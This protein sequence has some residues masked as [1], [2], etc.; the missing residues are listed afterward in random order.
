MASQSSIEWTDATWNP[1][2]GCS[3]ISAGCKFCYAERLAL[4]LQAMGQARY[5]GGFSI[6]LQD[7]LLDLPR[8]WRSPRLVF[9]NSMSD[10]FHEN[11]PLPFIRRVFETWRSVF[12]QAAGRRPEEGDRPGVGWQ[13]LR[14]AASPSNCRAGAASERVRG[15][16]C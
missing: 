3:K 15:G 6:T 14:R 7:D 10:L 4:R 11:V 2:T 12:L 5:A 1:V 16:P 8:R 9:V 13:D